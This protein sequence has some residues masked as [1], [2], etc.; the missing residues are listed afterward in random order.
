MDPYGPI[1]AHDLIRREGA[2]FWVILFVKY[3]KFLLIYEIEKRV[4]KG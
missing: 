3:E 2:Q 1:M 4:N